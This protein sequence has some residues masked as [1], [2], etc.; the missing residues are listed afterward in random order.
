MVFFLNLCQLYVMA[1][2]CIIGH[3]L[4]VFSIVIMIINALYINGS[5]NGVAGCVLQDPV[6]V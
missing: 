3:I 5:R 1:D 4:L 2:L 6:C